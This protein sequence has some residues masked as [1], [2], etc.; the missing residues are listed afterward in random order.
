[1]TIK[2]ISALLA[3]PFADSDIEWRFSSLN[4]DKTNGLVVAYVTNRAIQNRLDTVLG[5]GGWKNEFVPWHADKKNNKESQLCGLS[6]WIEERG[7]WLTKYDGADDSETE[8]IKGGL[9]DS[10]KRAAVQWGIGRYLYEMANV[11]ADADN[12]KYIKRSEYGKLNTAH[13]ALVA[14]LFPSNTPTPKPQNKGTPTQ[15]DAQAPAPQNNPKPQLRPQQRPN[16]QPVQKPQAQPVQNAPAA[17]QKPVPER[18]QQNTVPKNC[19]TILKAVTVASVKR[20]EDTKLQLED[21]AGKRLE[22]YVYY[23]NPQLT[24]GTIL[25]DCKITP[26][27]NGDVVFYLLE[28]YTIYEQQNAA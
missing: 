15:A 11:Y 17:P 20:K 22:V 6:I 19:F 7:E 13:Q 10:M 23:T 26:I 25:S 5:I 2:E 1:M 14:R 28:E 3:A 27:K 9:S 16:V 12:G 24:P 4:K 18:K 8:P 21:A